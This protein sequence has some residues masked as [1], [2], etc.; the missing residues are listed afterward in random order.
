VA[1]TFQEMEAIIAEEAADIELDKAIADMVET[2]RS[3][4]RRKATVKAI[5]ST[6]QSKKCKR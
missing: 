3:G 2:T 5:Q 1:P 4:R 6:E